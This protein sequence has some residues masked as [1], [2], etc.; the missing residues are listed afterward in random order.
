MGRGGAHPQVEEADSA[1]VEFGEN[2]LGGDVLVH[3]QK[4]RVVAADG[5]PE[6]AEGVT[7]RFWVAL[8]NSA[9]A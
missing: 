1:L 6:V 4:V 2:G 7:S 8:D 5:F 9:L 3:D